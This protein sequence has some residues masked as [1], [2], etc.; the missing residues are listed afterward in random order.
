M[1]SGLLSGQ[2]RAKGLF[3]VGDIL[4][5]AFGINEGV[6]AFLTRARK[7]GSHSIVAA[8]CSQ[9]NIARQR[10][11]NVEGVC[12]VF[13][14]SPVAGI[15][16]EFVSGIHIRAA[17]D[18]D[19]VNLVVLADLHRPRCT[20]FCVAGCQ[21]SG[22]HDLTEPDLISIMQ[23]LVDSGRLE[24][25]VGRAAVLKVTAAAI[26]YYGH[27]TRHHHVLCAGELLDERAAGAVVEMGV[28]D[29]ENLDIAETKSQALDIL[30]NGGDGAF[31]VAVDENVP[32]RSCDQE[33]GQVFAS[34]VIDVRDDLVG[35]EGLGPVRVVLRKYCCR[36]TQA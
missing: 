13:G 21:V 4:L 9:K 32:L 28:A 17:H 5:V 19:L 36:A 22:E 20:A 6:G 12:V 10:L 7:L 14:N 15:V 11:Q 26:F 18:H 30:L 31:E 24:E 35:R 1:S 16:D 23:N 33:R 34:D 2:L 8:V 25:H 3:P 29:K 27:I